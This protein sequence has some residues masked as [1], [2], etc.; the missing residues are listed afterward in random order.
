[1][2]DGGFA[3]S[4]LQS[5]LSRKRDKRSAI[6][7]ALLCTGRWRAFPELYRGYRRKSSIRN[8]KIS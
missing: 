8:S 4:S 3:L 6:R 5:N 1:M 2:P 7:R